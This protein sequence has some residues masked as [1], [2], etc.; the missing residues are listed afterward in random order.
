MIYT[1][2]QVAGKFGITAHTL[3][4]YDKE[5]LLPFVERSASGRR[6][7]KEEDFGWLAMIECLKTTGMPLKRIKQYIDWCGKGDATL[8]KRHELFLERKTAI[9]QQIKALE[10]ALEKVKYKCWYYKTAVAAG[11]EKIHRQ[12]LRKAAAEHRKTV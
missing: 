2:A 11:T 9:K 3:R 4:Y 6:R 1:I 7:F 5:G 12:T 8:Q 10:K